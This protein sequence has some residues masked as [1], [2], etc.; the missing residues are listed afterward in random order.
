M[1]KHT[2]QRLY[3]CPQCGK[4]VI[5]SEA[6]TWRPF[7]SERCRLVDI[8]KWASDEYSVPLVDQDIKSEDLFED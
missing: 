1:Q 8:G 6:N 2:E 3:D 5:W 4:S 7:C